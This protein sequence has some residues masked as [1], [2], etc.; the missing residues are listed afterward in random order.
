MDPKSLLG[1]IFADSY[2]LLSIAGS[3]GMGTVFKARQLGLDR[4]V[5]LKLLKPGL[6]SDASD[7]KRFEREAK[8]VSQ[9]LHSHIAVFYVYGVASEIPYFVMEWLEGNS[10]AFLIQKEGKLSCERATKIALQ[11][12]DAARYAHAAGIIH[13]DLKPANVMLLQEPESDFVKVVDFGLAKVLVT[14]GNDSQSLTKTGAVLGTAFYLSP[15]QCRGQKADERSDI[16]S[17]GCIL[18]EMVC[19]SPPFVADDPIAIIHKHLTGE[20]ILPSKR[21]IGSVPQGLESIIINC[22]TRE[23]QNRYQSMDELCADLT[24]LSNERAGKISL[25]SARGTNLQANKYV[26]ICIYLAVACMPVGMAMAVLL[27]N[28]EVF[29]PERAELMLSLDKSEQ[30]C[31]YWLDISE[32]LANKHKTEASLRIDLAVSHALD[33]KTLE[34]KQALN[35][36]L[37]LAKNLQKRKDVHGASKFAMSAFKLI[38]TELANHP[39]SI[40]TLGNYSEDAAKILLESREKLSKDQVLILIEVANPQLRRFEDRQ[41]NQLLT[42]IR[43]QLFVKSGAGL[44]SFVKVIPDDITSCLTVN[45]KIYAVR[46]ELAALQESLPGTKMAFT[47]VKDEPAW[48]I[49][50]HLSVVAERLNP[51]NPG[52]AKKTLEEAVRLL[53]SAREPADPAESKRAYIY[54]ATAENSLA[55]YKAAIAYLSKVLENSS[56]IDPENSGAYFQRVR[57]LVGLEKFREAEPVCLKLQEYMQTEKLT[58]VNW[59]L[60]YNNLVY[61]AD[62]LSREKKDQQAI[63]ILTTEFNI[64]KMELPNRSYPVAQLLCDLCNK[65]GMNF[66]KNAKDQTSYQLIIEFAK[67]TCRKEFLSKAPDL[68]L[69]R[70]LINC[71]SN[72]GEQDNVSQLRSEATKSLS[73]ADINS[74][75][76][77]SMESLIA[78]PDRSGNYAEA[79]TSLES[80][81]AQARKHLPESWPELRIYLWSLNHIYLKQEKWA[82]ALAAMLEAEDLEKRNSKNDGYLFEMKAAIAHYSIKLGDQFTSATKFKEMLL[83]KGIDRGAELSRLW[84]VYTDCLAGFKEAD[85][86]GGTDSVLRLVKDGFLSCVA[87][88]NPDI[89]LLSEILCRLH[90]L[91]VGKGVDELQLAAKHKLNSRNYKYLSDEMLLCKKLAENRS[92]AESINKLT[93]TNSAK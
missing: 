66:F 23:P 78:A 2:E 65:R 42:L 21:G 3:G 90:D 7:L 51:R 9:L 64:Y 25:K 82:K 76:P 74:V 46:G 59:S 62:L 72:S 12:A 16:Y 58:D 44:Q 32:K 33:L 11:I 22:L 39:E 55:G 8:A 91:N 52:A 73:A 80:S 40:S 70:D 15:E 69:L 63:S 67:D 83:L 53:H 54:L 41:M 79:E 24:L 81:A 14:P 68:R 6:I 50:E 43:R 45:D 20:L 26:R 86:A 29:L 87:D 77:N 57:A 1:T 88:K 19:G 56:S 48:S 60:R 89:P 37:S 13:R 10:L 61:L 47:L 4:I 84:Y 34:P 5:A 31:L 17:L 49:A 28:N 27:C 93:R 30:N 92:Y 85:H 36:C 38:E 18:Y 35:I 71:L 75:F